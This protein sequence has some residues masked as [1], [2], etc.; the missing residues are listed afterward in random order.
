MVDVI[1]VIGNLPFGVASVLLQR[2]LKT[3]DERP[4]PAPHE[5][6]LMFQLE[7]AERIVARPGTSQYG[8]LAITAQNGYTVDIPLIVRRQQF[9]PSPK[10]DA[11]VVRFRA[12]SASAV[13]YS[14]MSK[15]S[16]RLFLRRNKM[17]SSILRDNGV[18]IIPM[19]FPVP[20]DIRPTAMTIENFQQVCLWLQRHYPDFFNKT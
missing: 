14:N 8:R 2:L 11:A 6:I 3:F 7:V 4:R 1:S 9:V 15:L 5:F 12:Q 10:V 13:P 16:E 20:S 19:T 17:L 18:P